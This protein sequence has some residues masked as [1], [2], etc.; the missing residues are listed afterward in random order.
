[1][2]VRGMRSEVAVVE[3][4]P[5]GDPLYAGT[6]AGIAAGALFLIFAF[7]VA[8]LNGMDTLS[9]LRLIGA[10]FVGAG[11]LEGSAGVI[12]YGLLLHILTSAAWGVLFA[13]ILPRQASL[14]AALVGGIVYGLLVMLVML[15]V[16]LP[17]AN[18]VMRAAVDGTTAFGI[19]HL[20]Y[21]S[22]LALVPALRRGLATT[23]A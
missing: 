4:V 20:I 8:V 6:A 18:P 15:Y 21:G 1:M 16:V 19:E 12:V 13:S 22:A 23:S 10:T 9:P 7:G 17:I 2:A 14:G 5:V 3:H 11:A